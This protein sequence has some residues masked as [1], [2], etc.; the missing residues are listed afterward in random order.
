MNESKQQPE[1]EIRPNGEPGKP[2]DSVSGKEEIAETEIMTALEAMGDK[3][4]EEESEQETADTSPIGIIGTQKKQTGEFPVLSMKLAQRCHVGAR[5]KR[6][7]DSCFTFLSTTGGDSTLPP[8]GLFIV[9]DGMGGHQNGHIASKIASRTAG[10]YILEKL[11]LPL[12]AIKEQNTPLPIQEVLTDAVM[13]A[14]SAVLNHD[15]ESDSGT[16]LTIALILGRRLHIAHV[17]DSR[18]YLHTN[19]K[20]ETIT[21]DHSLVQRLQEVGQLTA[22]EATFY[23]YSNILLR[24]VGQSEELEVDTYMRLLPESGQILLC[25]DGLTSMISDKRIQEIVETDT[26]LEEKAEKLFQ[27][28][29]DA[30]GFDNI[31]VILVGFH[32]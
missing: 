10:K 32:S 30:G 3:V 8:F 1:E 21:Q 19:N 27:A 4:N 7:E 23:R 29:M 15:L 31:T 6:N 2:E 24:A 26:S 20:L 22:E 28:A 16:T 11:Y 18:V 12:L 25:S 13:A 5:R 14:N 17:G 9:A